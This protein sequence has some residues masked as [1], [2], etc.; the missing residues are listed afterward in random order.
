MLTL[1]F[2]L[3]FTL[4]QLQRKIADEEIFTF[5][6]EKCKVFP[7]V[8]NGAVTRAEKVIVIRGHFQMAPLGLL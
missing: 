2:F 6:S 7:S 4:L 3:I 1:I 8:V 5:F